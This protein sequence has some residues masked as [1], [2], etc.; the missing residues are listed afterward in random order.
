MLVTTLCSY[1]SPCER[2]Q[3]VHRS[4]VSGDE[5]MFSTCTIMSSTEFGHGLVKAEPG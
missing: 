2:S 3:D 5:V 1:C 4:V